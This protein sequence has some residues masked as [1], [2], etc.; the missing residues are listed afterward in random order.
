VVA[1]QHGIKKAKSS[2][3]IG[4]LFVAY[5][6]RAE[7]NALGGLLVE[8]ILHAAMRQNATQVLRDAA[9][10]Y[11]VDVDAVG[12]KVKQQFAAREV[13]HTTKKGVNKVQPKI[14]KEAKAA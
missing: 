9:I 1:R 8:I 12:F 2:D 4:K 10:A 11:K 6:R 14:H 13:A 5:L 7:E 3:S